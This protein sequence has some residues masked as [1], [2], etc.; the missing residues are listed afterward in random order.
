M[1]NT[2]RIISNIIKH[3][4]SPIDVLSISP[5]LEIESTVTISQQNVRSLYFKLS[6]IVHPDTHRVNKINKD[7]LTEAFQ[8]LVSSFELVTQQFQSTQQMVHVH[9]SSDK[10]GTE[11]VSP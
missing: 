7:R 8:I 5:Q 9:K 4:D 1:S 3:K 11:L 6:R 2:E 10:H